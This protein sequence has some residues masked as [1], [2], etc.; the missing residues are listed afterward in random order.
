MTN[1]V[2]HQN[3]YTSPVQCSCRRIEKFR[4]GKVNFRMETN[5]KIILVRLLGK[6]Q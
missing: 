6:K 2:I 3:A 5:D 4:S 1:L